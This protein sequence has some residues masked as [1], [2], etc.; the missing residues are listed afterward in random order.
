MVFEM[1]YLDNTKDLKSHD[2]YFAIL[3]RSCRDK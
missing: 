1:V 3:N 2:N